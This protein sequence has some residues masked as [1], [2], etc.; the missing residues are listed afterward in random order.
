[1][2]GWTNPVVWLDETYAL[3]KLDETELA[4]VDLLS[5]MMFPSINRHYIPGNL[6]NL[7]SVI[8]VESI[9]A[10][11]DSDNGTITFSGNGVAIGGRY[12][13]TISGGETGR[14]VI[15][16]GN[17]NNVKVSTST[18]GSG[19]FLYNDEEV[20]T[21]VDI[22][23]ALANSGHISEVVANNTDSK[24]SG[25]KVTDKNKIEIDDEVIFILNAN[26]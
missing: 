22:S 20:A 6:Q 19:K 4:F 23:N 11:N 25:L 15:P 8:H 7:N 12:G 14:D 2:I 1:M 3:E 18:N 5:E 16:D 9:E 10:K 26:F 21:T 24:H 17:G 13:V